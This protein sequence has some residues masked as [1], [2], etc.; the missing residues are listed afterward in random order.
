MIICKRVMT[1]NN[2]TWFF[3]FFLNDVL[4]DILCRGNGFTV[5]M[6]KVWF[7]R[8]KMTDFNLQYKFKKKKKTLTLSRKSVE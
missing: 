5:R 4:E 1:N 3:F 7:C 8:E 6:E 2:Y